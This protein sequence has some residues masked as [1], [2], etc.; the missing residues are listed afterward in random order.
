MTAKRL[1]I[2][3]GENVRKTRTNCGLSIYEL[4]E[5]L[6]IT[7]GFLGS[8]ERGERG[9]TPL[10]LLKLSKIF[11]VP[12]EHFF[13]KNDYTTDSYKSRIEA[14]TYDFTESELDFVIYMMEGVKSH[15]LS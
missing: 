11:N 1:R 15:T 6:G 3:M 13:F 4:A 12:I 7:H 10:A 8:I 5:L 9:T 14:L 2:I